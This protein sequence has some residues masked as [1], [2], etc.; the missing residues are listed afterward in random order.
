MRIAIPITNGVLADHFGECEQFA[1]VEQYLAGALFT[2][3]NLC[4]H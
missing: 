3:P 2:A 1:L 4:D